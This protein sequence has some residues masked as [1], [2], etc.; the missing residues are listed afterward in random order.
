MFSTIISLVGVF[1]AVFF[2]VYIIAKI[3]WKNGIWFIAYAICF[4]IGVTTTIHKLF[5]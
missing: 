3:C 1:M 5:M 2:G 4:T